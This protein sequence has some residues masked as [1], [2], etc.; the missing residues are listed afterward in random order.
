MHVIPAIQR[1]LHTELIETRTWISDV[2]YSNRIPNPAQE[3][4]EVYDQADA[5]LA[6]I[7]HEMNRYFMG[8]NRY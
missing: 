5:K 3:N 8:N 1:K 2:G 6:P 4:E 7:D